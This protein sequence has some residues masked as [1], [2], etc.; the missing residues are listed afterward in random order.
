MGLFK[1]LKS[2]LAKTRDR[3]TGGLRSVL[4]LGRRIDDALLDEI[5]ENLLL[6]DVGPA[7]TEDLIGALRAAWK[8]GEI[9]AAEDVLP[10]LKR[11]I[12]ERLAQDGNEVARVRFEGGEMWDWE[13][14]SVGDCP[15]GSCIYIA[16][17]GDNQEVR[18]QVRLLR[19]PEPGSLQ[20]PLAEAVRRAAVVHVADLAALP[21]GA[22]AAIK[23]Q[24]VEAIASRVRAAHEAR[25]DEFVRLWFSPEARQ[26]LAEAR[27]RF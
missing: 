4:T 25:R 16:D 5:E 24:R 1:K 12:E 9:K 7:A 2:G 21:A 11:R 10:F 23:D 19:I 22:A 17:T 6:A 14:L 20:G 18:P 15:S 26:L 13:D 8:D 3:L 27:E